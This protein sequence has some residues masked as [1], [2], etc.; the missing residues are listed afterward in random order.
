MTEWKIHMLFICM[1]RCFTV[2]L[3]IRVDWIFLQDQ[4]TEKKGLKQKLQGCHTIHCVSFEC[5][6]LSV[7][8]SQG[9]CF[10]IFSASWKRGQVGSLNLNWNCLDIVLACGWVM[11]SG[12]RVVFSSSISLGYFFLF[13]LFCRQFFILLSPLLQRFVFWCPWYPFVPKWLCISLA[14]FVAGAVISVGQTASILKEKNMHLQKPVFSVMVYSHW[15]GNYFDV[16]INHRR[17]LMKRAEREQEKQSQAEGWRTVENTQG[18]G[19]WKLKYVEGFSGSDW[20]S[21]WS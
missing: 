1:F 15:T 3:F 13:L 8:F 17:F 16:I 11:Q 10:E 20:L 6:V 12:S 19:R 21:L 5:R 14:S 4:F 2:T 18:N 9:P 7:T